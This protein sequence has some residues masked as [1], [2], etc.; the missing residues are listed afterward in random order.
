[1]SS[2]SHPFFVQVP[3][4]PPLYNLC[5]LDVCSEKPITVQPD[6]SFYTRVACQIPVSRPLAVSTLTDRINEMMM[7]G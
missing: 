2:V 3:P 1:M 5:I 7:Q 6:L 4:S